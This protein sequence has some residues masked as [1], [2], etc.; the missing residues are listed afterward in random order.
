MVGPN[1]ADPLTARLKID[2]GM[3]ATITSKAEAL[4]KMRRLPERTRKG[5]APEIGTARRAISP[6]V[7]SPMSFS[8]PFQS[9]S[10]SRS[11]RIGTSPRGCRYVEIEGP[12]VLADL[13][14]DEGV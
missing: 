9:A 2:P 8:R 12:N 4:A 10:A 3:M 1:D 14:R 6:E 13:A 7:T 11:G 5:A